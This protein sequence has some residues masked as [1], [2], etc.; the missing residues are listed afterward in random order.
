MAE[1]PES[2]IIGPYIYSLRYSIKPLVAKN[3]E[4]SGVINYQ[5]QT[6]RILKER[7]FQKR[8]QVVMHE[9]SHG[10]HDY[11]S[12]QLLK[13]KA[14]SIIDEFATGVLSVIKNNPGLMNWF[15]QE[16]D[17]DSLQLPE[18]KEMP[19]TVRVGLFDYSIEI[20]TEPI[21]NDTI[22]WTSDIDH[23]LQTIVITKDIGTQ[24]MQQALLYRIGHAIRNYRCFEIEGSDEEAI[25]DEFAHG[26]LLVIK[27]NPSLISW[28]I[29]N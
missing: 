19:T 20:T 8:Q 29:S 18:T 4:C 16:S 15:I 10:I 27:Q 5:D 12:F 23:N 24:K 6:I 14:D 26:M 21:L 22:E 28:I 13:A 11:R 25:V 1:M 3:R 2:V 9:I 17:E 7:G